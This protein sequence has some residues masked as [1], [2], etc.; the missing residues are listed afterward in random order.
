[1]PGN[2][3][4]R[5]SGDKAVALLAT[6]F[7]VLA[8][9]VTCVFIGVVASNDSQEALWTAGA[10]FSGVILLLWLLR[11]RKPENQ[12]G[13]LWSWLASRPRPKTEFR[14]KL[15]RPPVSAGSN[16]PPTAE[17]VRNLTGGINTWVPAKGTHKPE[18]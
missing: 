7:V 6:G 1:M 2:F 5:H 11:E 14:A 18:G 3:N 15:Q 17:T 9:A 4:R 13:A 16:A 10:C 12:T 8:G